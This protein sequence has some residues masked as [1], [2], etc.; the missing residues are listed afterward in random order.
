[1]VEN[2]NNKENSLGIRAVIDN[3]IFVDNSEDWRQFAILLA[4]FSPS[5]KYNI[6]SECFKEG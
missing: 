4:F 1:M 6:F 5:A 2:Y 3:E